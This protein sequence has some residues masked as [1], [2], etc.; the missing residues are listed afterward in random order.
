MVGYTT[1]VPSTGEILNALTWESDLVAAGVPAQADL[2]R[3][4][5]RPRGGGELGGAGAVQGQR[6]D[7]GGAARD[8]SSSS[9]PT[10]TT[11]TIRIALTVDAA[12]RGDRTLVYAYERELDHTGHVGRLRLARLAGRT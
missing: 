7:R 5:R 1:R 11:R 10:R 2:L 12:A 6:S 8:R 4:G 9:S 3:A